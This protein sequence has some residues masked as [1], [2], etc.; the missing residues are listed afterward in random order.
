MEANWLTQLD[1]LTGI[2]PKPAISRSSRFLEACEKVAQSEIT[3]Q[4]LIDQTVSLGF[5]NMIGA[6]H[7][8]NSGDI[9]VRFLTDERNSG[10]GGIRLTDDLLRLR[11]ILQFRGLPSQVEAAGS[12]SRPP[13]SLDFLRA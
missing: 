3:H 4:E 1:C 8:V 5:N 6:F 10:S 7:V 2:V 12:L 11:E 9:P 13:G